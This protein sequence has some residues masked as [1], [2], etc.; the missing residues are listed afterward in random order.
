MKQL[1]FCITPESNNS[2]S[3]RG[4]FVWTHDSDT[5][6]RDYIDKMQEYIRDSEDYIA[7]HDFPESFMIHLMAFTA[8]GVD[9]IPISIPLSTKEH[10]WIFL[11]I[12]INF[13]PQMQS[14]F[15]EDDWSMITEKASVQEKTF[16]GNK[17]KLLQPSWPA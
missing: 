11:R 1:Y 7:V 17:R 6:P 5:D 12:I 14:M 13:N 2:R 8:K 9:S 15:T 3:E 4:K 16:L 10:R